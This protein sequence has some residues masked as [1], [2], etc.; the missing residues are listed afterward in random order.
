MRMRTEQQQ[1]PGP[2]Q[3][4]SCNDEEAA[5]ATEDGSHAPMHWNAR[6]NAAG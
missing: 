3:R 2:R 4:R 1:Q 5:E 6:L